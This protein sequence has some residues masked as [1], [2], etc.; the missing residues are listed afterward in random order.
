MPNP[1]YAAYE[2]AAP[3]FNLVR[4]ALGDLVAGEHFFESSLR[5]SFTR[6]STTFLVGL[7]LSKGEP[8]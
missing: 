2:P 3:Y 8:P 5:T 6:F 1:K 4:A 7:A